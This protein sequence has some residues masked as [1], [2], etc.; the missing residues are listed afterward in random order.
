MPTERQAPDAILVQTAL[1]GAVTA[2]DE[3]PDSPDANW[4]TY[5]SGVNNNTDCRVSF[6][7]PTGNP[8]VGADLQNFRVQIRK[9]ASGGNSTVW[10]LQ[11]WEN[12]AQVAELAT[13]TTTALDP[14]EVVSGTWNASSLGTADGSLVECRLQQTSGGASGSGGNR[15]R[16]EIGAVEWNVD[17]TEG[18]ADRTGTIA[19][20]HAAQTSSAAGDVIVEGSAANS[21]P[22]QTG[23]LAGDV[24]VEGTAAASS[25]AQTS[26]AVGDVIVEGSIAAS[27]AAQTTAIVGSTTEARNGTIAETQP[28]Q[29][30][31]SAGDVVVNGTVAGSA[32]A[33]TGA[34]VADA[35][36][37]GTIAAQNAAQSGSMSGDVPVSGAAVEAH[38]AQT[39]QASGDV[40]V[41]G[42]LAATQ[43]AQTS[44]LEGSTTELFGAIA[45]I[46]PPQ[47]G[48]AAGEVIVEGTA[49][50][51][52]PE[53]IAAIV[54]DVAVS[55]SLGG[56]L[57]AQTSAI[58]GASVPSMTI[59]E[60]ITALIEEYR[61]LLY[62]RPRESLAHF[63][64][65]RAH[66]QPS[67]TEWA[68]IDNEA[69]RR[70][71]AQG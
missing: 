68:E 28:A 17:Y 55:G 60:I 20:S 66:W 49:S 18:L 44:A 57:P 43:P 53:Q 50:Y 30:S 15:R 33:Q 61:A 21:S 65:R 58:V 51:M 24:I 40:V 5:D 19:E 2:I 16:I 38:A 36:V 3:D 47:T 31:S 42:E 9:N 70:F 64:L 54:G 59:Q 32:A 45:E 6:P 35:V 11:L 62:Q 37:D 52:A 29:T 56:S 26:A 71:E 46:H 12:G 10:S 14:G 41:S 1:T 25:P 23:S 8:T 7:T 27:S 13:G 63:V 67:Q 4:L 69:H 34:L 39:G 22:A 48:A